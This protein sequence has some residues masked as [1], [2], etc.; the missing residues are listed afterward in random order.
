MTTAGALTT[1]GSGIARARHDLEQRGQQQRESL[2][3]RVDHA[4][5]AQR[6]KEL[7]RHLDR[8]DRCVVRALEQ[9]GEGELALELER[10]DRFGRGTNDGEDRPFDGAHD[11]LIRGVGAAAQTGAQIIGAHG[12]EGAESL[13]EPAQDLGGDDPGVPSGPHERSPA[14]GVTDLVHRLRGLELGAHRLEGQGHVGAG[15]AVGD[16]VHV[17]PVQLLLVRAQCIPEPEHG[18]AQICG[19]QAGQRRHRA[20]EYRGA[21]LFVL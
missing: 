6:G 18:V 9:R 19:G 10:L 13:D 2:T 17:E 5:V 21:S 16:R 15:V 1:S 8:G 20:P 14:H 3:A 4:G 7:R 12:V 11:G